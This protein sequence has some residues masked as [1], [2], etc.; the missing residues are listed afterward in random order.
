MA[1]VGEVVEAAVLLVQCHVLLAQPG[2]LS[3]DVE[4]AQLLMPVQPAVQV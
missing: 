4:M 2:W 3:Q 1:E